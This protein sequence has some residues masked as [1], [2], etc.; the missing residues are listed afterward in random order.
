[1][2]KTMVAAL[3][4]AGLLALLSVPS[5]AFWQRGQ[6]FACSDATSEA[7]RTRLRCWEL[8]PYA[9]TLP[10]PIGPEGSGG[11]LRHRFGH[12]PG[13]GSPYRGPVARRLG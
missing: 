6:L 2:P 5:E 8:D 4:G 7:E 13:A 3:I 12:P 1:M 10:A 9:T 11:A